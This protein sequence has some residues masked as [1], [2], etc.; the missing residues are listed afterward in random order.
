MDNPYKVG[1]R[2]LAS[3]EQNGEDHEEG[4]VVDA[5]TLLIGPET[6]PIVVVE[7]S[8][9]EQVRLNSVGPDVLPLPEPEVAETG[10]E[11]TDS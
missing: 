8:D 10:G 9:G 1:D 3:R 7:L 2:V 5:Y 4:T 11:E 6:H